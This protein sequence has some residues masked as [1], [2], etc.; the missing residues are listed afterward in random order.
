[1]RNCVCA[2][3]FEDVG[4]AYEDE[5]WILRDI[6]FAIEPGEKVALV[7]ATGAG[8]TSTV[9]LICRFYDYQK[10]NIRFDGIDLKRIDPKSL[11]SQIGLVLQ[12]V[13]LFSG[14][15]AD[16]ISLGSDSISRAKIESAVKQVGLQPYIEQLPDGLDHEV[17]ERGGL[18]SVGQRQLISFAR[19]LAHDPRVMIL[20]EATSSVDN[21]TEQIIQQAL[22]TL[23][24][25]RTSIIVAHRLSTIKEVDKILVFH[26]GR[27]VEVGKHEELLKKRQVYW[28]L[29]QLQYQDQEVV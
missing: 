29:Y 11:R 20:D 5:D 26:K 1:L 7:G 15:I 2:V 16:N 9:S 14:S 24:R 18:L 22:R 19:A 25:G 28:R 21:Q 27:I 3:E 10:G 17:G 12:D 13:F 8:K 4:F 6:S 23:F